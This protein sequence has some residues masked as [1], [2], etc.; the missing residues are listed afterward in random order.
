MKNNS[1]TPLITEAER[2]IAEEVLQDQ[3]KALKFDRDEVAA[4][5]CQWQRI[6]DG[7]LQDIHRLQR[8]NEQFKADAL[9]WK[10][11]CETERRNR[12]NDSTDTIQGLHLC[13]AARDE[14]I[15]Q[16]Q[17]R[18]RLRME[19]LDA[20]KHAA[21]AAGLND[22]VKIGNLEKQI[23]NLNQALGER[24]AESHRLNALANDFA[25]RNDRAAKALK[26]L[27]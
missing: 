12:A 11:A 4:I 6:A 9:D 8:D 10:H 24:T 13:V 22:G 1:L 23:K 5:G 21:T 20:V 17:E 25:N 18:L 19:E 16:L 27:Q 14:K 3:L 7:R 15:K 2:V 26:G